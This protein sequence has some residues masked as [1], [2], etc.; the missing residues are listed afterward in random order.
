MSNE[1]QQKQERLSR[2]EYKKKKER[3]KELGK[4][5]KRADEGMSEEARCK[6]VKERLGG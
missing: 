6:L 2:N 5:E 3:K 1:T 4:K